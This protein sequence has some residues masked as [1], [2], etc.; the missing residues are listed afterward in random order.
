MNYFKYL[1]FSYQDQVIDTLKVENKQNY[2]VT[3]LRSLRAVV[4]LT[5]S[6]W[7]AL[8]GALGQMPL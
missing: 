5:L 2:E 7:R 8:W 3:N 1:Q 4:S 6:L